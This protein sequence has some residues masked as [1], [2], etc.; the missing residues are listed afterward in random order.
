MS[1]KSVAYENIVSA[2]SFPIKHMLTYNESM[3]NLAGVNNKNEI[4]NNYF[5]HFDLFL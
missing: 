1:G 3:K 2:L 4:K 5:I